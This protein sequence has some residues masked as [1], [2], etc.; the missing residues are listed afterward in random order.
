MVYLENGQGASL[1][2]EQSHYCYSH[3]IRVSDIY[4]IFNESHKRLPNLCLSNGT[5]F[6]QIRSAREW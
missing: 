2:G 4:I 3:S 5:P 1:H 6:G